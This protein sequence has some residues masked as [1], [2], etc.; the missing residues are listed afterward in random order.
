MP[1]K[2]TTQE[3]KGAVSIYLKQ[4]SEI[5]TLSKEEE[6]QIWNKLE[7]LRENKKQLLDIASLEQLE[8]LEEEINIHQNKLVKAH[9]RLVISIAKR[10][11]NSRV[12]FIDIIDEGNIGL[13]EAVKRFDYKKGFKFSTYAV[14][15][16]KHSIV[17]AISNR[18]NIVKLPIHI[19]RLIKEVDMTVKKL[20]QKLGHEPSLKE[21][22]DNMKMSYKTL[23]S[24]MLFSH[25]I[26]SINTYSQNNDN[27]EGMDY[28]EDKSSKPPHYD[29]MMKS[30]KSSINEVLKSLDKRE[31]EVI[32]SRFGLDG[33]IPK[34]LEETG[35]ELNIT[36]ERV[37]Q[38]Q[39]K[40][41]KKMSM[42]GMSSELK[43]F[44]LEQE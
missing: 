9:L 18:N 35:A 41:L 24:I 3:Y 37:R 6:L 40:A 10:Y 4:I 26:S 8:D 30:L 31:R 23:S 21:I 27:N 43:I 29:V 7:I 19:S 39:I 38:I 33:Q 36:R 20:S 28:L 22:A 11:F 12:P 15:W 14:W 17:K 1:K 32:V 34:T 13:I 25:N 42:Y 16:I 2:D 44:L 5:K